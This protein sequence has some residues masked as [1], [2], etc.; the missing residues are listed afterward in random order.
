MCRHSYKVKFVL[1]SFSSHIYF[2]TFIPLTLKLYQRLHFWL[3][4]ALKWGLCVDYSSSVV[5][6]MFNVAAILFQWCMSNMCT[7]FLVS[8]LIAFTSYM[9]HICVFIFHI[10]PSYI[11]NIWHICLWHTFGYN[12]LSMHFSWL[13]FGTCVWKSLFSLS[14]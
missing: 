8:C 9:A 11:W 1:L 13:C 3:M 6:H 10:S 14:I 5:E 7:A 4:C 2:F 12:M